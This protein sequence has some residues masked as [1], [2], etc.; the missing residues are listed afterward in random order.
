ML[1]FLGVKNIRLL[2]GVLI[3]YKRGLIKCA[4]LYKMLS[5]VIA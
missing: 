2:R 5:I 1:A 3:I 4:I